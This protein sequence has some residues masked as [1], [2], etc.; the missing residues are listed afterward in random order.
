[1]RELQI[2]HLVIGL[3]PDSRIAHSQGSADKNAPF[4]L[5]GMPISYV[6][7]RS[8]GVEGYLI[9]EA[10]WSSEPARKLLDYY[11]RMRPG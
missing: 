6:L 4:A 9:G 5:Y 3:D 1:M 10:D 2:K 7:N 11:I 8:G